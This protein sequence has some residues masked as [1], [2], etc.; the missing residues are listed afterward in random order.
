VTAPI[1][2]VTKVRHV[3]EAVEALQ[4]RL[5]SNDIKRLEDVYKPHP[6][7]GHE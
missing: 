2:G 3:E 6:V 4:V 7:I 1:I 5:D